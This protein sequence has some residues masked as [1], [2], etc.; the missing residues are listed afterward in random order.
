MVAPSAVRCKRVLASRRFDDDTN[1]AGQL[2]WYE[3]QL[4]AHA[5]S[6]AGGFNVP[7]I[8]NASA[9]NDQVPSVEKNPQVVDR[10]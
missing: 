4:I 6:V 9:M 7:A 5:A 10:W 3:D 2:T 1:V 8:H